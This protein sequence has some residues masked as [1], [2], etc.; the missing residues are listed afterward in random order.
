M[1]PINRLLSKKLLITTIGSLTV[2]GLVSWSPP[3]NESV[4]V[5]P[6]NVQVRSGVIETRAGN[7]TANTITTS[8]AAIVGGG[9]NIVGPGGT[10][11]LGRGLVVGAS[12][13]LASPSGFA[14]VVGDSNTVS[15]RSSL[16]VG[17]ENSVTTGANSWDTATRYSLI[18]GW[19][20][21]INGGCE[22]QIVGGKLNTVNAYN[23]LVVGH[24]NTV[25]GPSA[26]APSWH[27][28]AIGQYNHVMATSGWTM[29]YSNNVSGHRGVAIGSGVNATND[30]SVALG[31]FNATMQG[32][33]VLVIGT[34][35][36]DTDRSTA[37]RVTSDGGVILG[38]AQGDISMGDF[39]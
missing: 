14:A 1:K 20:N 29:G 36:T 27:S 30:Q 9:N 24:T 15:A 39:Q 32:N 18:V 7:A 34:G 5:N 17:N 37:L 33:D 22:S 6:G 31:R 16:I 11:D 35:N 19:Q 8:P 10:N 25:E 38:R 26:G 23:A 3:A 2:L 21:V 12:N 28:A 13:R 4:V